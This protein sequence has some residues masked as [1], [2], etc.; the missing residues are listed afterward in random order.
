MTA[1]STTST[2]A[3]T[4]PNHT[5]AIAGGVVGGIAAVAL[6]AGLFFIWKHLATNPQSGG[7]PPDT[8]SGKTAGDIEKAAI[9]VPAAPPL[10]SNHKTTDIIAAAI[11][12]GTLLGLSGGL[13]IGRRAKKCRP[14]R[15]AKHRVFFRLY[16]L[17]K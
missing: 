15:E 13:I 6:A 11:P 9:P 12:I 3:P 10:G 5:G 8:P 17:I 4:S 7:H 1:Q 14:C 16:C 2:S